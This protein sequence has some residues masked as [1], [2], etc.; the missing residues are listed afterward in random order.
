M[1]SI[2]LAPFEQLSQIDAARA[3]ALW[4]SN[5]HFVFSD[6]DYF[7]TTADENLFLHTWSLAVEEQF[8]LAW[9]L[10]LMFLLGTWRWQGST[11]NVRRLMIGL[12]AIIGIGFL[13]SL[14]LLYAKPLWAFYLMPSRVWQFA[15]GALAWLL[16]SERIRN[17]EPITRRIPRASG[18]IGLGLIMGAAVELDSNTAYP[19]A[20]ALL[21]SVGTSLVL[22]CGALTPSSSLSRLLAVKPLQWIGR[23]S[24]SWYLWHWPFMVYDNL[25]S[26]SSKAGHTGLAL[27]LSL[28]IAVISY[29]AV[30]LPIRHH[31]M[32]SK[33]TGMTVVG[34]LIVMLMFGL[35]SF[36]WQRVAMSWSEH[37]KQKFYS[38]RR[39]DAP[40]IYQ[41]GCDSW[42]FSSQVR[43]CAFGDQSAPRTAVLIGDSIIGQWFPAFEKIFTVT[44][45]RFLVLTKSACPMVD[46]PIF[47]KRIGMQ[48][49]ICERWRKD[50]IQTLVSL[51]PDVL[52]MGQA[53][54]YAFSESQWVRGTQKIL[55]KL[56]AATGKIFIV[57][58]TPRLPFDGPGCLAS[59]A[60]T[61]VLI[62]TTRTCS[63]SSEDKTDKYVHVWLKRAASDFPNVSALDLNE[64]VCPRGRCDAE[65]EGQVVFRDSQH[66]TGSYA[67]TLSETIRQK[68]DLP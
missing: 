37:P 54:T 52:I 9:P 24:Y 64:L 44:G 53:S 11:L 35:A 14:F 62:S 10:L 50:A 36:E 49:T 27:I 25:L 41:L 67:Q 61:S 23:I 2:L 51:K 43:I 12:I 8:Y 16:V 42:Y 40:V 20:W 38:E 68:I 22:V 47:Y 55:T 34:S 56:A 32:L 46:E 4:I 26:T 28:G 19:G 30:E 31:R 7:G 66:L 15:M 21:P 57:R 63:S 65:R 3:A 58:A 39:T 33:R 6:F 45:W 29:V 60:W 1:T 13:Y 59:R 48:Y 18:W 5:F 17:G